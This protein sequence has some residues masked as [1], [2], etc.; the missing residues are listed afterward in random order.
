MM[1]SNDEQKGLI[2]R[3]DRLDEKVDNIEGKVNELLEQGQVT[4]E[5]VSEMGD[6][7]KNQRDHFRFI[8]DALKNEMILYKRIFIVGGC[9]LAFLLLWIIIRI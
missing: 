4:Q 9:I 3:I 5:T 8:R 1:Y 2:Q 6:E 7:I